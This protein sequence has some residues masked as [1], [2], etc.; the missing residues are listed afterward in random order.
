M[1]LQ[2][3][4]SQINCAVFVAGLLEAIRRLLLAILQAIQKC[5]GLLALDVVMVSARLACVTFAVPGLFE[6]WVATDQ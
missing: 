5:E 3:I 2:I 1:Y 4:R 6:A